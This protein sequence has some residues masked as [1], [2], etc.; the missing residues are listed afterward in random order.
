MYILQ[1]ISGGLTA[2]K[3]LAGSKESALAAANEERARVAV[4][5]SVAPLTGEM[6]R[7]YPQAKTV[8]LRVRNETTG[9]LVWESVVG[10]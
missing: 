2:S 5:L 9:S 6:A 3:C 10:S 4:D 8:I 7:R 1:T